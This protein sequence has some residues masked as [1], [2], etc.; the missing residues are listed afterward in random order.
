MAAAMACPLCYD[1]A[2]QLMTEGVQLDIA[3]RAVLAE[4]ATA[5][6]R[7]RITA[8]VKGKDAVGDIITSGAAHLVPL[9]VA[10]TSPSSRSRCRSCS[11]PER[12]PRS[13][14]RFLRRRLPLDEVDRLRDQVFLVDDSTHGHVKRHYRP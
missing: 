4:P 7:L 6:G 13:S 5:A 14:A 10:P 9:A 12:S 2:R 1:A 3:D 8:I 11:A